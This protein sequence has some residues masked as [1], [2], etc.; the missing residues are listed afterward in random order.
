MILYAI[1]TVL[2]LFRIV[3]LSLRGVIFGLIQTAFYGY[4]F[5][6]TYSV[7]DLFRR[8]YENKFGGQ[9]QGARKPLN[10]I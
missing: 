3:A 10:Q 8:E 9:N 4:I 2:S 7:Y 1:V 6:V 5:V